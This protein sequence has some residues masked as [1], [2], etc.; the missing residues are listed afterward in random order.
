M[1][2][3]RRKGMAASVI[4]SKTSEMLQADAK[5][6][7]LDEIINEELQAMRVIDVPICDIYSAPS[8]WNEWNRLPED[9]ILQLCQ[10]IVEIGQ[11]AP[12][13]LW[14]M[15]KAKVLSLYD[16]G[17]Q[18]AYQFV[19][20][21]YMILSGH[22]RAFA[23]KLIGGTVEHSDDEL[24]QVVPAI[25]YEEP[26]SDD[27]IEK[28]K[29]IIDD[30]NYLSRENTPKEIMRAIAKK[31]SQYSS[32][33]KSS[34]YIAE[35]IAK[36]LNLSA[37]TVHRYDKVRDELNEQ[38]RDNF[39][40]EN[41]ISFNDAL[42]LCDYS[43]EV[44]QY[45]FDHHKGIFKSKKEL[46]KFLK[47]TTPDMTIP[48]IQNELVVVEKPKS[49]YQKITVSVPADKVEEFNAM[50]MEWKNNLN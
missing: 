17:E 28:A 41:E 13:I 37:R 49:P 12:C 14:K 43:P 2:G 18:D 4:T 33:R 50:F 11:Q 32:N 23:R 45:L 42:S 5:P 8:K 27:F 3:P 16:S 9:K 24:Y 6:Q 40:F 48:E 19:G 34:K 31:Y 29:Q 38:I 35:N 46:K 30:T 39:L 22:N 44:Q 25:I 1:A 7:L 47:N 20:D 36:S 26:I 21:K 10:S 15:D